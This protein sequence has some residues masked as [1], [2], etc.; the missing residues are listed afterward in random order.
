VAV[1]EVLLIA[2]GVYAVALIIF[3]F[4]NRG[5]RLS[6]GKAVAVII[7][8]IAAAMVALAMV[9]LGS[10]EDRRADVQRLAR[11]GARAELDYW[12]RNAR[13]TDAVRLDLATRSPEL[14][15]LLDNPAARLEIVEVAGDGQRVILRAIV[16]TDVL[17]QTVEPPPDESR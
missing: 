15:R 6:T 7:A 8:T 14:D 13:F 2:S 5:R 3:G 12:R 10:N 17:E 9:T 16:G 11:A 1:F 4:A